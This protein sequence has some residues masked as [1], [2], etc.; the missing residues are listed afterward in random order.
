MWDPEQ[1]NRFAD[2]RSRPFEDL[3]SRVDSPAPSYVVDLGC[4]PGALTATLLDRWP[5]A[6]V[7]GVDSSAEMLAQA[8]RH[9]DPP[10]LTFHSGDIATWE[11]QRPVDVLVAN[12][13]LQWVPDHRSLIPLLASFLAPGGWLA[14]Q[15][16]ANFDAPTHRILRDMRASP[17]WRAAFG[18]APVRE[19][20]NLEPA[21]YLDLLARTGCAVDAW[22]TTY[23]HVLQGTDP[24]VDWYRGTGLRPTLAA[25]SP[26][27]GRRFSEEY[28]DLLREEYPP[29]PFGTVLPF[30]RIFVVAQR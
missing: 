15:V 26:G 10:Q 14:F 12:A 30:R 8:Q 29:E 20:V 7:E 13:A 19:L 23:L 6:T 25:L 28:A 5:K 27:D 21:Q 4:G 18:G 11:P 9:A 22:E 17:R 24:I 3:L 16:P 2:Q 1:Y